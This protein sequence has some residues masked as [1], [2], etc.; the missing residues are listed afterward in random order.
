M[1]QTN[2]GW[3]WGLYTTVTLMDG[4]V[5]SRGLGALNLKIMFKLAARTKA[6]TNFLVPPKRSGSRCG[7]SWVRI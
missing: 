1:A 3:V 2:M 6:Q 7:G 4:M 5:F